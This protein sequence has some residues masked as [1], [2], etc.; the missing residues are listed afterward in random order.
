MGRLLSIA[1]WFCG[2]AARDRVFDP[3]LADWDRELRDAGT[4]SRATRAV[5]VVRGCTAFIRALLTCSV[6]HAISGEGRMWKYGAL[7]FVLAATLSIAFEA[8]FIN[9][10]VGPDYP[11]DLLLIA[12]IR[13][14]RATAIASALLP[15]MFLLRR[16]A[17]VGTRAAVGALALGPALVMTGVVSQGW[18]DNYMPSF[19][20]NERM[21]QRMRAND[22]AGRVSYPGTMVRELRDATSTPEQRRVRSEQFLASRAEQVAKVTQPTPWERLRRSNATALGILF[23]ITGWLLAGVIRPTWPRA[24]AC[25]AIAWQ[26]T[27]IADGRLSDLLSLPHLRFSWWTLPAILA[28]MALTLLLAERRGVQTKGGPKDPPLRSV[29]SA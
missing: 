21:F 10:Q 11:P 25:W 20:Q 12:A 22:L 13:F 14:S 15:A 16:D 5:I 28:A 26:L 17:R 23:G 8:M 1:E 6:R 27:M 2:D 24:V 19:S 3:L 29:S 4:A 9:Y 18:L 7:T